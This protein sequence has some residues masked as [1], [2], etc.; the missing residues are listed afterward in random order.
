ME[1][2][3]CGGKNLHMVFKIAVTKIHLFS[4]FFFPQIVNYPHMVRNKVKKT[5]G[6]KSDQEGNKPFIYV[7]PDLHTTGKRREIV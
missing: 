5:K 7:K 6:K 2:E 3:Y 4:N 1:N